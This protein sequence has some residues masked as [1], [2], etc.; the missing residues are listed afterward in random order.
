MVRK[1]S[2]LGQK[3]GNPRICGGT[4]RQETT[5]ETDRNRK[6]LED[7]ERVARGQRVDQKKVQG[8]EAPAHVGELLGGRAGRWAEAGL[9]RRAQRRWRRKVHTF[10]LR[11]FR[12]KSEVLEVISDKGM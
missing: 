12:K 5:K 7:P 4:E 10:P 11:C 8:T 3:S 2:P 9:R 1:V 6:V